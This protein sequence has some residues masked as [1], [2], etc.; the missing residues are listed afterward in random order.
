[1]QN[2]LEY[3]VE[4]NNILSSIDKSIKKARQ[5]EAGKYPYAVIISSKYADKFKLDNLTYLPKDGFK[6]IPIIKHPAVSPNA[7][8]LVYNEESLIQILENIH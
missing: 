3:K 6:S 8:K 5:I 4:N 1:M 2:F 7:L